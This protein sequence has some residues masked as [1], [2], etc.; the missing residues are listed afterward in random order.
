[1]GEMLQKY[2]D[3]AQHMNNYIE[4]DIAVAVSDR[5]KI[6]EY[7]PGVHVNTGLKVG[8]PL[9]D[10]LVLYRCMKSNKQETRII[11]KELYGTPLIATA[12]P[13][14]DEAGNIVGGMST[15]KSISNK[16]E[17]LDMIQT[18]SRSLEEIS[19]SIGHISSSAG[20]IAS[21]GELVIGSVN[22]TL[23]RAKETDQVLGFVQQVAKQTNLLGLNAAIEAARAGDAG[24]G[25][26]VV[27]EEIRKLAISSNESV[28]KIGKVL[29]EIQNGVSQILQLVEKNGAITQE[30]AAGTQEIT[31]A[32]QDLTNLSDKLHEFANRL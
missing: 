24:R 19:K 2:I 1:M 13:I 6:I 31:S 28:E 17:L 21:S 14:Q 22:E 12:Y 7:R 29:K 26:Q 11:P 5:E 15:I 20:E 18:F 27:A 3:F 8:D 9:H 30:Q 16:E 25:F 23:L 10:G 32:I 4:D